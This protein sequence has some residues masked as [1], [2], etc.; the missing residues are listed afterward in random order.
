MLGWAWGSFNK[1]RAVTRYVE[2]VFLHL[3]GSVGHI[4][5]SDA[6]GARNIDALFS[7]SGWPGSVSIKSTR[8]RYAEH[9]FLHPVGSTGHIVHSSVSRERNVNALFSF[10]GGP[11]AVSIKIAPGHITSNLCF[12]LR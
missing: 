10:S 8:T 5:H 3:L 7:C 1:K 11:S 4:L 12:C 9:V 2:L 6:Y